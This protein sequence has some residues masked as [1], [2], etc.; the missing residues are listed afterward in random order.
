MK[1][2]HWIQDEQPIEYHVIRWRNSAFHHHDELPGREMLGGVSFDGGGGGKSENR[3]QTG[4]QTAQPSFPHIVD[5]NLFGLGIS[6]DGAC[7]DGK[8]G[9]GPHGPAG[10]KKTDLKGKGRDT[11]EIGNI[12]EAM[13]VCQSASAAVGLDTVKAENAAPVP[14][15]KQSRSVF[16]RYIRKPGNGIRTFLRGM[17]QKDGRGIGDFPRL[18]ASNLPKELVET[19]EIEYDRIINILAHDELLA[20]ANTAVCKLIR[21]EEEG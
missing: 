8:M 7:R 19:L 12:Q 4:V 16:L 2:M 15:E 13:A 18:S 14:E 17:G 6:E 1:R 10:K 21:H 11:L 20:Y 3:Q 9:D 5:E